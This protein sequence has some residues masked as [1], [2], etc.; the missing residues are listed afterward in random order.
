MLII[1]NVKKITVTYEVLFGSV[2]EV[3]KAPLILFKWI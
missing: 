1:T 3:V 2:P